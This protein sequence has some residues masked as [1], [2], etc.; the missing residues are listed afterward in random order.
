M[1]DLSSKNIIK[2]LQNQNVAIFRKSKHK[3]NVL[4]YKLNERTFTSLNF[5]V[6]TGV[7]LDTCFT[8]PQQ[9]LPK[10]YQVL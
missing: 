6:F 3:Q 1:Y 5:Q 9:H 7:V 10:T 4:I 8:H 2:M